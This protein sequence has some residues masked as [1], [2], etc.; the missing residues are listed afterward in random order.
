[1]FNLTS[2]PSAH[3][4]VSLFE[5]VLA[6]CMT[7]TGKEDYL[8]AMKYGRN[9]GYFDADGLLTTSGKSFAHFSDITLEAAA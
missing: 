6:H 9:I 7:K 5:I 8:A 1:M 3:M 2:S 4:E